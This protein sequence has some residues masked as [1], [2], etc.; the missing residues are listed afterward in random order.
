MAAMETEKV[1]E[2]DHII[3]LISRTLEQ[4]S[5]SKYM[6][7]FSLGK[8]IPDFKVINESVKRQINLMNLIEEL[9]PRILQEFIKS[10]IVLMFVCLYE[11]FIKIKSKVPEPIKEALRNYSYIRNEELK[12]M[13]KQKFKIESLMFEKVCVMF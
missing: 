4:M 13:K 12:V 8:K 7:W 1:Q 6:F 9:M 5:S 11:I 3:L 2:Q 10:R